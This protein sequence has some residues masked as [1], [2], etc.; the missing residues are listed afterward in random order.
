MNY[1][2]FNNSKNS[3]TNN[4]INPNNSLITKE[5]EL[6]FTKNNNNRNTGDNDNNNEHNKNNKIKIKNET[7]YNDNNMN[8]DNMNNL[9]NNMDNINNNS[10]NMNNNN[11][12]NINNNVNND[13]NNMN[14]INNNNYQNENP[15]HGKTIS[16]YNPRTNYNLNNYENNKIWLEEREKLGKVIQNLKEKISKTEKISNVNNS[17]MNKLSPLTQITFCYYRSINGPYHKF[18]PL[19]NVNSNNLI[20]QPYNFIKSTIS[21]NKRLDIIKIVP[22]TQ[23]NYIDIKIENIENTIVN[24]MIKTIIEIH[25][26][27]RRF[28]VNNKNGN[29]EDFIEKEFE[30]YDKLSKNDIS[31]C[32]LNKSFNFSLLMNNNQRIEILLCSYED[33]KMWVNGVAFIIKNKN[34]ILKNIKNKDELIEK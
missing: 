11:S 17:L 26:N 31:K 20:V 2:E 6:N 29:L 24:S 19:S 8:N 3:I 16:A 4:N 28:K 15:H 25:R 23:L 22:S 13:L 33:F 9:N 18:N 7:H 10:N 5:Q 1:S 21:L 27:Y 12:N 34:E 30:K 14:N 32:A